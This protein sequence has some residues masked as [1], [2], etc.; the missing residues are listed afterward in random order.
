VLDLNAGVHFDEH[1]LTSAVPRRVDKELNRSSVLISNRRRERD[2]VLQD[3]LAQNGVQVGRGR[4]LDDLLVATLNRAVSL[5]EVHGVPGG[6]R[7]NLHLNVPRPHHGLFNKHS[8]IAKSSLGLAHR[9]FKGFPQSLWLVHPAH[10]PT[11]AAGY[12]LR[13]DRKADLIGGTNKSVKIGGGLTRS[14]DGHA[15]ANGVFLGGHLVAGHLENRG[16]WADEDDSCFFARSCQVRVFAQEAISRIDSVGTRE[17]GNPD[18]FSDI[19][20]SAQWVSG[21]TDLVGLVGLHPM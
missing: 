5:K 18:D 17:L 2:S 14:Q 16:W 20:I 6:I 11:A 3:C 21:L 13:E 8:P 10:S 7:K 12:S 9:G 1:V 4:N 19:Q 15:S